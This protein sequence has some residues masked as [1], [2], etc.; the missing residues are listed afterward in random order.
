M[1]LIYIK[2]YKKKKKHDTTLVQPPVLTP[3]PRPQSENV[4]GKYR[5]ILKCQ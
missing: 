5:L 2:L 3:Q 4:V 1:Q